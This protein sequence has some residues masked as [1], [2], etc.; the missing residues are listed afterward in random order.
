MEEKIDLIKMHNHNDETENMLNSLENKEVEIVVSVSNEEV[1]CLGTL[2][3]DSI[4]I[5][6]RTKMYFY[7]N[8]EL[9][10]IAD[11]KDFKV[12]LNDDRKIENMWIQVNIQLTYD[13]E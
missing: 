5:Y 8:S 9:T 1:K 6:D 4:R 3:Y 13:I 2:Y 12:E 10:Y 11:L 7:K